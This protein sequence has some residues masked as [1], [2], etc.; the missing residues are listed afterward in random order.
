MKSML[1][2]KD[3]VIAKELGAAEMSA[4]RGGT[5]SRYVVDEFCGT[6]IP[7]HIPIKPG[8][9][10]GFPFPHPVVPEVPGLVVPML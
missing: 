6:P 4:V 5:G 3:L 1:V 2:I 10:P 7:K 8:S 9:I